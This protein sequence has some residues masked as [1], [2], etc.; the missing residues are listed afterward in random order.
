MQARTGLRE[1]VIV[2]LLT[3]WARRDMMGMMNATKEE[4]CRRK[5]LFAL[6]G[7]GYLMVKP[8][9]L[10]EYRDQGTSVIESKL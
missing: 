7:I 8:L 1:K 10:K 5:K 2:V 9:N 6:Y 3:S 4:R